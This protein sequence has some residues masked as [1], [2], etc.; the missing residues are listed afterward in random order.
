MPGALSSRGCE[1]PHLLMGTSEFDG[2]GEHEKEY[3]K[4]W[5]SERMVT[6]VYEISRRRTDY[7]DKDWS[8]VGLE[9]EFQVILYSPWVLNPANSVMISTLIYFEDLHNINVCLIPGKR[10]GYVEAPGQTSLLKMSKTSVDPI[11]PEPTL[12]P[13]SLVEPPLPPYISSAQRWWR[14]TNS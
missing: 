4:V 12:L 1:T 10:K 13:Y 6:N 7:E 5:F 2:D 14:P 11:K 9:S 3:C 8:Y